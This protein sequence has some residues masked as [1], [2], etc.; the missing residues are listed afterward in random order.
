MRTPLLTSSSSR[1]RRGGAAGGNT[2]TR[3]RRGPGRGTAR[4]GGG[5]GPTFL[6]CKTYRYHGHS[7]HDR[8]TYRSAEELITWESRDP[9]ERWEVYLEK[10]KYDIAAIREETGK[11]VKKI[12]ADAVG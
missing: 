10:K 5:E 6:E 7:E 3:W 8:A 1:W 9:I 11:K 2:A 4:A 12:V